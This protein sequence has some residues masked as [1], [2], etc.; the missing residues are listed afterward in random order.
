MLIADYLMT[1]QSKTA[2]TRSMASKRSRRTSSSKK[3]TPSPTVTTRSRSDGNTVSTPAPTR[4]TLLC[5][6]SRIC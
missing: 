3:G 1:R 6:V 5:L 2:A 4:P